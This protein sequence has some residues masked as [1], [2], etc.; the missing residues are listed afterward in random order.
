MGP[1]KGRDWWFECPASGS[2]IEGEAR[3]GSERGCGTP[4]A[5]L[6]NA[7]GAGRSRPS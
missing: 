2:V 3:T 4:V 5:L 6:P 1:V 7:V